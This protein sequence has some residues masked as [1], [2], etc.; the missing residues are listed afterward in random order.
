MNI[1]G[2]ST[3]PLMMDIHLDTTGSLSH[4]S[5]VGFRPS[6]SRKVEGSLWQAPEASA[7]PSIFPRR[8]PRS[9]LPYGR[10]PPLCALRNLPRSI[11]NSSTFH[12]LTTAD[13]SQAPITRQEFSCRVSRKRLRSVRVLVN[14]TS[15]YLVS[16]L[17][18]VRHPI[19][20]I[21][22]PRVLCFH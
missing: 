5:P 1:L 22:Q 3:S 6:R 21:P 7:D 18:A 2:T 14:E 20:A 8:I 12:L 11:R 15:Q 13:Y 16:A 17:L 9:A 10:E 4:P 19:F